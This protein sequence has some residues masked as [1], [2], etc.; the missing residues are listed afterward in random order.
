M[1]LDIASA[2][3]DD[4]RPVLV[5]VGAL[6]LQSRSELVQAGS[7]WLSTV[8]SGPLIVDLAG[9]SFMDSTGI[10]ALVELSGDAADAGRGFV[11]RNPSARATRVLE[12]TG[13][14]DTW[15]VEVDAPSA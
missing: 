3:T 4:G 2:T 14:F 12:I 1:E 9:V 11:V 15:D 13:L 10:G 6:D 7:S 8:P 5:V